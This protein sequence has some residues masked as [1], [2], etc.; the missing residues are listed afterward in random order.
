MIFIK[1]GS[2]ALKYIKGNLNE[3]TDTGK[4]TLL[5]GNPNLSSQNK[6]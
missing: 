6:I 4:E 2:V 5:P 1:E 3:V